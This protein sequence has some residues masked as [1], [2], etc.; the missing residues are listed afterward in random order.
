MRVVLAHRPAEIHCSW[1]ESSDMGQQRCE[2]S[3][4]HAAGSSCLKKAV[5]CLSGYLP[6]WHL[7]FQLSFT[8]Q[9]HFLSVFYAGHRAS[10]VL[11]IS[12]EKVSECIWGSPLGHTSNL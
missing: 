10:I 1:S 12:D 3:K 8:L 2:R 4:E 5:Q 7:S 6:A 11:N 9:F